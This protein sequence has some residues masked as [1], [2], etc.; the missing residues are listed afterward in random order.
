MTQERQESPVKEKLIQWMNSRGSSSHLMR[1]LVGGYIAYLG[2]QIILD[3]YKR[4][5]MDVPLLLCALILLMAGLPVAG[6]SLYAVFNGYSA[7]YKGKINAFGR[8]P[9]QEEEDPSAEEE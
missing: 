1:L 6:I 9:R 8:A 5:Q 4:G 7:E 3:L 2:V